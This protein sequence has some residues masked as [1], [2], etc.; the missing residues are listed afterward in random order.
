MST[1]GLALSD[2]GPKQPFTWHVGADAARVTIAATAAGARRRTQAQDALLHQA[3]HFAQ[4]RSRHEVRRFQRRFSV[5]T[6]FFSRLVGH[7][8]QTL[9][10]ANAGRACLP[11]EQAALRP[12]SLAWLDIRA[13]RHP[14]SRLRGLRRPGR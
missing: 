5:E 1:M 8:S 4:R 6:A 13:D 11:E 12:P 10:V 14:P 9:F 2:N 7:S 3:A